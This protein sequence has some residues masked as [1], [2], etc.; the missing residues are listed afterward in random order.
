V[1][2]MHFGTFPMLTGTR[3]DLKRMVKDLGVEVVEIEPEQKLS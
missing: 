1:I 3:D 2:P